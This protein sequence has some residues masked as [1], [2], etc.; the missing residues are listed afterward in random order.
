MRGGLAFSARS[1][2]TRLAGVCSSAN[3]R[4]W[5][6]L[7]R[8]SRV[9]I[10]PEGPRPKRIPIDKPVRSIRLARS[11]RDITWNMRV[12]SGKKSR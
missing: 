9:L 3:W 8:E 6:I 12:V 7:T 1:G 11:A 10:P 4:F 2:W 5:K